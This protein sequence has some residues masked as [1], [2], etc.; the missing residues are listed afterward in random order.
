MR[1]FTKILESTEDSGYRHIKA[2]S[3]ELSDMGMDVEIERQPSGNYKFSASFYEYT[4]EL[5]TL[6]EEI[7][8]FIAKLQS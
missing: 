2:C 8:N 5:F 6:F 3:L 1:K 4:G 7:N